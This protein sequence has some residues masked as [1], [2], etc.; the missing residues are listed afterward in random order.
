MTT[1]IL[2]IGSSDIGTA[3]ALRLFRSGFGIILL[4]YG[5][6]LDLHHHRT[7]SSAAYSGRKTIDEITARTAAGAMDSGLTEPDSDFK[8][9][10]RFQLKNREIPFITP[11]SKCKLNGLNCNY[12]IITDQGIYSAA[13]EFVPDGS[14]LI[15]FN[16]F[17]EEIGLDFLISCDPGYF[18]RVIYP[19][20]KD[21]FTEEKKDKKED[22]WPYLI[23]APLEGVF[24]SSHSLS[25]RIFEKDE[26]GKIADIPILSPVSGRISGL[27]NSGIFVKAKTEFVEITALS[28]KN[29]DRTIPRSAFALAGG[30]LEA[31]L[32]DQRLSKG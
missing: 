12:T 4:E 20:L 11:Q 6:P 27:L 30:I 25:D 26:I 15:G 17:D 32:Y 22:E 18:G 19:S 7:F 1:N 31:I 24:V 29:K 16:D 3:C 8:D 23:R 10:I 9:F 14:K 5:Q 2:I 28:S 13:K 21:T